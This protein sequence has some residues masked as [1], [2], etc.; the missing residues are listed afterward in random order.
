MNKELTEDEIHHFLDCF[1]LPTIRSVI[2]FDI[3]K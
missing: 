3:K 1:D 2:S